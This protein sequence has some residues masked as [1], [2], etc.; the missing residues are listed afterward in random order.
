MEL[1]RK[2]FDMIYKVSDDDPC[3]FYDKD[4]KGTK[5][6]SSHTL[7]PVFCIVFYL[8]QIFVLCCVAEFE[9]PMEHGDKLG[10]CTMI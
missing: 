1:I 7:I 4:N 5:N 2:A 8:I 10:Q 3:E 9:E 6:I